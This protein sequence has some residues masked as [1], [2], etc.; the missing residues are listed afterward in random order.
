VIKKWFFVEL[1]PEI[2]WPRERDFR[3]TTAVTLSLEVQV[4]G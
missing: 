3:T 2:F 4:G 1:K